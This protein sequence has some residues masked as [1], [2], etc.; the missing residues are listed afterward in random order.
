MSASASGSVLN[1]YMTS[2]SGEGGT[3][4][5]KDSGYRFLWEHK[6]QPLTFTPFLRQPASKD[7][8]T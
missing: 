2:E 7:D 5:G 1:G 6:T 4:T 8:V 3:R